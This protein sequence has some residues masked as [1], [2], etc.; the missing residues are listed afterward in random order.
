MRECVEKKSPVA[1]QIAEQRA[2]RRAEARNMRRDCADGLR[3]RSM[4]RDERRQAMQSC[5]IAK[6]PEL[7]KVYECS[8]Q[9]REKGF[10][11]GRERRD[12][13]RTCRRS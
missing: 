11:S 9:A 3:G 12:F 2:S 4:S 1:R 6:R 10:T 5:M 7:K 8:N 13:M